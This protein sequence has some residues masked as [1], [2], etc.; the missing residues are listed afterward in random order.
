MVQVLGTQFNFKNEE[1][2]L[3][4]TTLLTGIVAINDV[5]TKTKK[6]IKPGQQALSTQAGDIQLQEVDVEQY[7]A[8]KDGFYY[9]KDQPLVNILSQLQDNF[10]FNFDKKQIPDITLTLI[11][12]KNRSLSEILT[13]IEKSSDLA[14]QLKGENL[15][16]KL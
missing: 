4:I 6:I 11:V 7:S 2:K 1:G 3:T 14:L 15:K 12:K 5:T 8:W 10:N 9:F 16:I 13:L